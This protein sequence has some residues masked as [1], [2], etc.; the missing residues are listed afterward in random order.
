MQKRERSLCLIYTNTKRS[1]S[2]GF[3]QTLKSMVSINIA[4]CSSVYLG[5]LNKHTDERHRN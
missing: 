4:E 3:A 2:K 1:N 5:L